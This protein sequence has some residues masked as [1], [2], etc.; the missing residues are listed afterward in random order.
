MKQ[1]QDNEA[2]VE[3]EEQGE[4][5]Q[6]VLGVVAGSGDLPK[7]IIDACISKNRPIFVIAFEGETDEVSVAHVPHQ[8]VSLGAVG[9]AVKVLKKA[10]VKEIILAGRVGR[11]SFASMKLDFGG[12][13]LLAK[14]LGKK[15]QGD[16][17]IFSTV[18]DHL[19]AS[20]FTVS[21]I[22][23]LF[24]DLLATEGVLGKVKPKK[25]AEK[26]IEIGKEAAKLIGKADIGQAVIVQQG[27]II[28]VE[29]I[30]GTDALIRRA[31]D[32]QREGE[33]G[34]LVKMKKPNQD[35]RIDLPTI[36]VTTIENIHAA[37]L[38]GVAVEAGAALIIHREAVIEKANELNMFVI[39]IKS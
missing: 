21:G 33:G 17:E 9:K 25:E 24:T 13:R 30:E 23:T 38:Q 39:G 19:E 31:R 27:V 5:Q 35:A 8:W 32:L 7:Q 4:Q 26:D 14:L 6:A 18:I 29:A 37:G 34:V 36:G 11:P 16:N 10:Q 2:I 22:D 12:T 20:G 1:Q 28:G 3:V 15:S